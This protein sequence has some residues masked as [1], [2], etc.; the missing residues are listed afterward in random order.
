M[1][2]FVVNKKHVLEIVRFLENH[3]SELGNRITVSGVDYS[4]CN[5]HDL[6][7]LCNILYAENV[8]SVCYKY[9]DERAETYGIIDTYTSVAETISPAQCIMSLRCLDYQSCETDDWETTGAKHIIDLIEYVAINRLIG[10]V[11]MEK[12]E[13]ELR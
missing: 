12:L 11:Q 6:L 1:S 8:R 5:S 13:W 9:S 3:G 2:A 10:K 4:T 7:T